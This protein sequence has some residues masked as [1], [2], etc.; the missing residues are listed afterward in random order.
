MRVQ[1]RAGPVQGRTPKKVWRHTEYRIGMRR[2]HVEIPGRA[3]KRLP[4]VGCGV[5]AE[6]SR[7]L[8]FQSGIHFAVDSALPKQA[9]IKLP[10]LAKL[11]LMNPAIKERQAHS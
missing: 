3:K 4:G 1:F 10:V 5:P 8:K 6:R 11:A 7:V 9:C 2:V